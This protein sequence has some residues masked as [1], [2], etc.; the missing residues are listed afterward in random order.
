MVSGEAHL[1]DSRTN[2]RVVKA[3]KLHEFNPDIEPTSAAPGPED[4]MLTFCCMPLRRPNGCLDLTLQAPHSAI[5]SWA[6]IVAERGQ[7]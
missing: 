7:V 1:K 6:V 4:E 5:P 2:R 3:S